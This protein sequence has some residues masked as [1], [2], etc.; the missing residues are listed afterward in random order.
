MNKVSVCNVNDPVPSGH[1]VIGNLHIHL[2]T[3]G[4]QWLPSHKSENL[5]PERAPPL[6]G[7]ETRKVDGP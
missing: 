3:Q 1:K 7:D 6:L 2:A 5:H 4:L